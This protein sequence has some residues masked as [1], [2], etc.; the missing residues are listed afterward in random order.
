MSSSISIGRKWNQSWLISIEIRWKKNKYII[1]GFLFI[2]KSPIS[3][4]VNFVFTFQKLVAFL[5]LVQMSWNLKSELSTYKRNSYQKTLGEKWFETFSNLFFFTMTILTQHLFLQKIL[6]IC[7]NFSSMTLKIKKDPPSFRSEK[8]MKP[9]GNDSSYP[10][11]FTEQ[12]TY[13]SVTWS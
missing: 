10:G 2:S 7:V 6:P 1:F 12:W 9:W 8:S 11:V 5:I 3:Y 4:W 13:V